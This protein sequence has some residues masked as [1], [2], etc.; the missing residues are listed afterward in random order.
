MVAWATPSAPGR[1]QG[2]LIVSRDKMTSDNQKQDV[3]GLSRDAEH[4]SGSLSPVSDK[5]KA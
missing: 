5:E 1:G 3:A 2:S 4:T